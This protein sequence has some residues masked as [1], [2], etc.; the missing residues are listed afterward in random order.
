MFCADK[1]PPPTLQASQVTQPPPFLFTTEI[2]HHSTS[3]RQASTSTRPSYYKYSAARSNSPNPANPR[4]TGNYT[5][6]ARAR[7]TLKYFS[8]PLKKIYFTFG[9]IFYKILA[10]LGALMHAA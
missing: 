4:G 8:F 1:D 10:K 2:S 7:Y 6:P 5:T 9:A 3:H